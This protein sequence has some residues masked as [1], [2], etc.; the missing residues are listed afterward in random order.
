VRKT[1]SRWREGDVVLVASAPVQELAAEAALVRFLWKAA[2]LLTLSHDVGDQGLEAALAEAALW[3]GIG[4]QLN[5]PE[6]P[7]GGAAVLACA[8]DDLELLGSRGLK[9][10]GAAGGDELLGFRLDDLREAWQT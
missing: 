8:P 10:I 9:V 7:I 3:S 1:P 4:A 6:E 5:L 2:P